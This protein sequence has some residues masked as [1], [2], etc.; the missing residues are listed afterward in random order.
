MLDS[1]L[2]LCHS[3]KRFIGVERCAPCKREKQIKTKW[4]HQVKMD[5]VMYYLFFRKTDTHTCTHDMHVYVNIKDNMRSMFAC[6]LKTYSVHIFLFLWKS[7]VVCICVHIRETH[8][9]YTY[10]HNPVQYSSDVHMFVYIGKC[11]IC[12]FICKTDDI[13]ICLHVWEDPHDA[14][15]CL[16]AYGRCTFMCTFVSYKRYIWCTCVFECTWNMC[17]V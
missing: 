12:V 13:C 14:N 9:I 17:E 11:M 16:C 15:S 3:R 6:I 1:Y 4:K 2:K 5:E 8:M 7:H 10:V